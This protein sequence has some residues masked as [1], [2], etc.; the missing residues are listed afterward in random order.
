MKN[1]IFL[2]EMGNYP[3]STLALIADFVVRRFRPG[4]A[5][6]TFD[7]RCN[8]VEFDGNPTF[9]DVCRAMSRPWHDGACVTNAICIAT[10]GLSTPRRVVLL[11][12]DPL[13]PTHPRERHD[14]QLWIRPRRGL[15][16]IHCT[17]VLVWNLRNDSW[18]LH[19]PLRF[20]L[21]PE[22]TIP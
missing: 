9:D 11:T 18:K 15:P 14:F 16:P 22:L 6:A 4:D 12:A 1:A 7:D 3:L 21:I 8:F 20:T 13:L 17:N 5:V 2:V 10:N 19:L